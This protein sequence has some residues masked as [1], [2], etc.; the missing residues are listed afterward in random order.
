MPATDNGEHAPAGTYAWF[1][2]PTYVP[3]LAEVQAAAASPEGSAAA[4]AYYE[5]DP[6]TGQ[7]EIWTREYIAGLGS[8]IARTLID[9]DQPDA[10]VLE[11]GAGH[12][13][14][15]G[16]LRQDLGARGLAATV[17][18]TD[19]KPPRETHFPVERLSHDEALEKYQPTI[20]L[21]SWM[22]IHHDWTRAM[23]KTPSVRDYILIGIP[24]MTATPAAWEGYA[25][26][27]SGEFAIIDLHYLDA[28]KTQRFQSV[29]PDLTR[30]F[31]RST[32]VQPKVANVATVSAL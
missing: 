7:Y 3:S 8:Y 30:G 17:V 1:M 25:S 19:I 15:S 16:L 32:D 24:D 11:V 21:S 27:E 26:P 5:L 23:R 9:Y 22:L 28:L 14:L 4:D 29:G 10:T 6:R 13:R 2:D 31:R 12:G 20:A 18:A